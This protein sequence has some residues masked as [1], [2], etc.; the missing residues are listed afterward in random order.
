MYVVFDQKVPTLFHIVSVFIMKNYFEYLK[1][2]ELEELEQDQYLKIFQDSL[3]EDVHERMEQEYYS[4]IDFDE[5]KEI[6]I[7]DLLIT[8]TNSICWFCNLERYKCYC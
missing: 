2:A 4:T 5:P 6:N 3:P 8:N 1:T 7:D